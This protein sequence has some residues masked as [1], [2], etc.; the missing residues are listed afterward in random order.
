MR[1]D[2][3]TLAERFRVLVRSI[4]VVVEVASPTRVRVVI[5]DG[6]DTERVKMRV[7]GALG[8]LRE[9][10]TVH[11]VSSLIQEISWP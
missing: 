10:F 1:G 4:G 8:I 6:A 9:P 3:A 11:F 5:Y 7:D 2:V